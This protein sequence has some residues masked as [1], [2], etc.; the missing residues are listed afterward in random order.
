MPTP[1]TQPVFADFSS[2]GPEEFLF[3]SLQIL[4]LAPAEINFVPTQY[5][6]TVGTDGATGAFIT[7]PYG[8]GLKA[9]LSWVNG[10]TGVNFVEGSSLYIQQNGITVAS[11]SYAGLYA[12]PLEVTLPGPIDGADLQIVSFISVTG[13]FEYYWNTLAENWNTT[14]IT[15]NS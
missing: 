13:P 11:D 2:Q 5:Y 3:A 9:T 12:G 14:E 8:Y 10:V 4:T 6:N 7:V 1:P 15:W